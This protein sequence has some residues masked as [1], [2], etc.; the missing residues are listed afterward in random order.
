MPRSAA[1][2]L[3]G[4]AEAIALAD[5]ASVLQQRFVVLAEDGLP[6]VAG[7]VVPCDAILVDAVEQS[8]AGLGGPVDCELGVV[9]LR[10]LQMARLRPGL[11][12]PACRD[13]PQRE[14]VRDRTSDIGRAEDRTEEQF[15]WS[16]GV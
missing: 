10:L 14:D 6:V 1:R 7:D 2:C 4:E 5:G 11:L 8:Q 16:R 9:R 13:S 12:G 3:D 15:V